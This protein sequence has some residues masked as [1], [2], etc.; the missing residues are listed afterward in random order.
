VFL[1]GVMQRKKGSSAETVINKFQEAITVNF[2]A[3]QGVPVGFSY[4][5][6]LNPELLLRIIS[7]LLEYA[8][9]QVIL[10]ITLVN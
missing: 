3:V 1:T 2:R 10:A 7:N 5:T 6:N 9:Q 8:P 4:F